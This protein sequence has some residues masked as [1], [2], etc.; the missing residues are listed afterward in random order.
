MAQWITVGIMVVVVFYNTIAT[1]VIMGEKLK[2]I[3]ET[4][5]KKLDKSMYENDKVWY[6]DALTRI[7]R[8]LNG[9]INK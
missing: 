4:L 3:E 6:K 2:R 9:K 1:H 7:E 8:L 5:P